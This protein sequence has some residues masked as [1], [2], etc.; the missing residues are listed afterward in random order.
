MYALG[1]ILYEL[2]TGRPP[3]AGDDRLDTMR[4]VLH[5]EPARPPARS[6]RRARRDLETICLK[7][8]EKDPGGGT[9]RPTPGRRPGP[10]PGRDAGPGP[11]ARPAGRAWRWARRHPTAAALLAVLLAVAA[12][13]FPGVTA[14]W[15]EARANEAQAVAAEGRAR[16][17][18]EGAVRAGRPSPGRRPTSSR[19]PGSG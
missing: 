6:S 17:A 8:L 2:L 9:P 18:E 14:L 13:G 7:C 10:V 5:E 3:F 15:L 16:A 19:T 4:Q 11:A 12:V 1:A